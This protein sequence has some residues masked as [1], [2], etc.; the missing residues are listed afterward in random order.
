MRPLPPAVCERDFTRNI[1]GKNNVPSQVP[2]FKLS[3]RSGVITG[4]GGGRFVTSPPVG[5]NFCTHTRMSLTEVCI[6]FLVKK[7][8]L[9][10]FALLPEIR[11]DPAVNLCF[12]CF[13]FSMGMKKGYLPIRLSATRRFQGSCKL[14]GCQQYLLIRL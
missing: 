2:G 13:T 4:I 6:I 5:D 1:P 14:V 9:P 11:L 8:V 3:L 12:S 10:I 7:S